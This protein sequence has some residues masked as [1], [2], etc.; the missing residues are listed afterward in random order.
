[1]NIRIPYLLAALIAV[2]AVMNTNTEKGVSAATSLTMNS[3]DGHNFDI[4]KPTSK[5]TLL[6]FWSTSCSICARDIPVLSALHDQFDRADLEILAISMQYDEL[7]D[8]RT[9]IDSRAIEYQIAY[10]ENG[11]IADAFPG[12]RF[13]PTSFLLDDS[14]KIIWRHTGRLDHAEVVNTVHKTLNAVQLATR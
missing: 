7:E 2:A 13:T 1:M 4:N 9:M 14:G 12:V 3:L 11:K 6:S 10:D 5:A 8:I